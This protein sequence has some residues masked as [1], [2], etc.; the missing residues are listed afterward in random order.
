MGRELFL[1]PKKVEL[2]YLACYLRFSD[3]K[4]INPLPLE[5]GNVAEDPKFSYDDN[6]IVF[7]KS[8]G[9][10]SIYDLIN[11]TQRPITSTQKKIGPLYFPQ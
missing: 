8:N 11:K 2:G 7:K 3:N 5:I 1:L 4:A 6:K 9:D 10:I